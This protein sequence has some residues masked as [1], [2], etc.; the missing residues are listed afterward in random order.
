VGAIIAHAPVIAM[1]S[2]AMELKDR[3][4]IDLSFSRVPIT[5]R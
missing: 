1:P 3:S 4:A 5:P 2:H